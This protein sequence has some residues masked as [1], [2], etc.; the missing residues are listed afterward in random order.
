MQ[1]ANKKDCYF[2]AVRRAERGTKLK[3]KKAKMKEKEIEIEIDKISGAKHGLRLKFEG[4]SYNLEHVQRLFA[5]AFTENEADLLGA[6]TTVNIIMGMTVEDVI[7]A[8]GKPEMRVDL[9]TKVIL[10]YSD[11][12]YIFIDGKLHSSTC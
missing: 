12:K 2:C 6:E 9:G 10:E 11:M 7:A 3:I 5:I 4:N 8:K 1:I